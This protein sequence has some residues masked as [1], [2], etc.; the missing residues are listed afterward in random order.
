MR[1]GAWL[2]IS[3]RACGAACNTGRQPSGRCAAHRRQ[4][5]MRA[6]KVSK[7]SV[8]VD[9]PLQLA[10]VRHPQRAARLARLIHVGKKLLAD[11][12]G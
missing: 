10:I 9:P 12:E 4:A 11:W 2:M 5:R 6:I 3:N 1:P 8:M 7:D